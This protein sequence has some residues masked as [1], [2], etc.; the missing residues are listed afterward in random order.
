MLKKKK[1]TK[2]TKHDEAALSS[3]MQ[4]LVKQTEALLG[5]AEDTSFP[6]KKATTKKANGTKKTTAK[7]PTLPKKRHVPHTKGKSFDIIAH[8]GKQ[9]KLPATLKTVSVQ[10]PVDTQHRIADHATKEDKRVAVTPATIVHQKGRLQVGGGSDAG[11]QNNTIEQ[12]ETSPPSES[13]ARTGIHFAET[14]TDSNTEAEVVTQTPEDT[15]IETDAP[16]SDEE[17][18][19][20]DKADKL[21]STV[22]EN[23]QD[24]SFLDDVDDAADEPKEAASD[25]A[26]KPTLDSVSDTKS[27]S[28]DEEDT[29]GVASEPTAYNSGELYANNLVKAKQPKGY[30]PLASQQK[31]TVF[32]T[33]QYHAEL[34]DWSK[35]DHSPS[36]KWL[37][38]FLLVVV[39]GAFV[40]LFV[41]G[42]P[43]PFIT[44]Q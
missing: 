27:S 8:S 34:H 17:I 41:L 19:A 21:L 22:D 7:K 12:K 20:T 37:I 42:Q 6:K 24:L 33:T 35:L 10:T 1:T 43:L 3:A 32:D 18:E 23:D 14:D 11:A 4:E 36:G 15:T 39:L 5:S 2:P 25:A 38:L 9:K 16:T 29:L 31:P 26:K 44:A 40:Y 30:T 13:I 28:E